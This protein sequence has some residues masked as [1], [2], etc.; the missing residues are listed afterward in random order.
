[1]KRGCVSSHLHSFRLGNRLTV[2]WHLKGPAQGFFAPEEI[3]RDLIIEIGDFGH[4][5]DQP[6][7]LDYQKSPKAPNVCRLAL[8]IVWSGPKGRRKS[9]DNHWIEIAPSF[10]HFARLLGFV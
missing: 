2:T 3:D 4:G 5:A 8:N 6:I 1:M 10:D 7:I 9:W